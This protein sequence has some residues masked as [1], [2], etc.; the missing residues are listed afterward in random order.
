MHVRLLLIDMNFIY[1]WGSWVLLH[2]LGLKLVIVLVVHEHLIVHWLGVQL[3]HIYHHL[4][5]L[6]MFIIGNS[7]LIHLAVTWIYR[8]IY[9]HRLGHWLRL[10]NFLAL[11]LL[12]GIVAFRVLT[13]FVASIRSSHFWVL[14]ILGD[15]VVLGCAVQMLTL[16]ALRFAAIA[17]SCLTAPCRIVLRWALS[18][19]HCG[20]L[21]FRVLGNVMVWTQIVSLW[22]QLVVL[23]IS[24]LIVLVRMRDALSRESAFWSSVLLEA[25]VWLAFALRN[26]SWLVRYFLLVFFILHF[27]MVCLY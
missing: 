9:H 13:Y 23:G 4:Q 3:I 20:F 6:L 16:S 1:Q 27:V 25:T 21:L 15:L 11:Q 24:L 17:S 7:F 10:L 12:H 14:W 22:V 26:R 5:R 2:T 18:V 8:L 19:A